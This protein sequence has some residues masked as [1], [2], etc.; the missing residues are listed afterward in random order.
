MAGDTAIQSALQ[1]EKAAREAVEETRHRAEAIR[2]DARDLARRIETRTEERIRR[3]HAAMD[4]EIQ[5]QRQRIEQEGAGML[6]QMSHDV[7]DESKIQ[8]GVDEVI[9]Q[10]LGVDEP[11]S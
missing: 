9:H 4:T 7:V 10:L 5:S 6:R 8:Q 1:A 11:A 2:S 3:L